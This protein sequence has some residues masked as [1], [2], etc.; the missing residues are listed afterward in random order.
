MPDINQTAFFSLQSKGCILI[1]NFQKN[2]LFSRCCFFCL[3][4]LAGLLSFFTSVFQIYSRLRCLHSAVSN[5]SPCT[6]FNTLKYVKKMPTL[7][8]PFV[9]QSATYALTEAASVGTLVDCVVAPGPLLWAAGRRQRKCPILVRPRIGTAVDFL[10]DSY[11][12]WRLRKCSHFLRGPDC[13]SGD[14]R[15]GD[16]RSAAVNQGGL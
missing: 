10:F 16:S 11:A 9:F 2:F 6:F 8:A 15:S 12:N 7:L 14:S 1:H 4:I 3:P 13:R 5:E